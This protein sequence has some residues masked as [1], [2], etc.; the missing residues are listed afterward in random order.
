[1]GSEDFSLPPLETLAGGLVDLAAVVTCPDYCCGRGL[2]QTSSPVK[3][4]AVEMGLVVR[5]PSSLKKGDFIEWLKSVSPDIIVLASYGKILPK[6]VLDVPRLGCLNIHPSL[7][8]R[9][10][11]ATPVEAAIMAG[12]KK[13]GVTLFFMDEGCDTGDILIQEETDI[14]EEETGYDLSMR[15]ARIG[16]EMLERALPEIERGNF[17]R[18]Q[19]D[20][21]AGSYAPM[22]KKED[23][24][25]DWK[26]PVEVIAGKVRALAPKPGMSTVFRGKILKIFK[27]KPVKDMVGAPGE[28][29]DILKGQGP[30]IGTGDGGLLL[31]KLQPEGKKVM[32]GNAFLNGYQP[33]KGEFMGSMEACY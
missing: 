21:E 22:L 6:A 17:K 4:K 31:L 10:R 8:P 14:G 30:V 5:E 19:Q 18:H 16:A 11:G 13:T 3:K 20:K 23:L 24:R 33:E 27:G 15:L 26:E 32:E 25:V 1:M 12:D 9:H 29:L 7:L 2:K 28:I